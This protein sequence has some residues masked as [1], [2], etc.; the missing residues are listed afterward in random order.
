M[1]NEIGIA[2]NMKWKYLSPIHHSSLGNRGKVPKYYGTLGKNMELW[3]KNMDTWE[4]TRNCRKSEIFLAVIQF[5]FKSMGELHQGLAQTLCYSLFSFLFATLRFLS[6]SLSFCC[7]FP[8]RASCSLS[9]ICHLFCSVL[10]VF[11]CTYFDGRVVSNLSKTRT[12]RCRS[13]LGLLLL[14]LMMMMQEERGL[15]QG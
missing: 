14:L 3:E 12:P 10:L 7:L 11:H 4:L 2:N 5:W 1:N 8:V 13:H 9:A 15:H 6:L